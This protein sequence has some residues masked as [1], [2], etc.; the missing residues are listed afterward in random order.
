MEGVDDNGVRVHAGFP[1]PAADMSLQSLN[2]HKL[3]VQHP[4]STFLF[5]VR[6]NSWEES[7]V[8]DGDVAIIDRGLDPRSNDVV[9]WWDEPTSE[10]A[11]GVYAKMPPEA[12]LWGVVTTTIHEFRKVL[13]E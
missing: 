9:V 13:D 10:F 4:I 2:L 8:F 1:N 11:I 3:L 12:T 5:R 6:G 7:G